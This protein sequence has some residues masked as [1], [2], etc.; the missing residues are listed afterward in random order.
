MLWLPPYHKII[1]LLFHNFNFDT[2]MDHNVK[3]LELE[4]YRRCHNLQVLSSSTATVAN[5]S[6]DMFI[7]LYISLL[8]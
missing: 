5:E 2:V 8:R 1:L 6:R 3:F 4:I 7:A